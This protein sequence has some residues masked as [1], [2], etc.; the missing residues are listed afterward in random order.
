MPALDIG[1]SL[2]AGTMSGKPVRND[3]KDLEKIAN[4][5]LSQVTA[6]VSSGSNAADS[7]KDNIRG[8]NDGVSVHT[9]E[10]YLCITI[11]RIYS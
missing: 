3:I 2:I 8:Y 1:L 6:P 4:L 10:E 5:H 11:A 7:P 9:N